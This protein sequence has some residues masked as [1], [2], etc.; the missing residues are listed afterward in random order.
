M[1]EA[2]LASE[3]EV[4][5]LQREMMD[6]T[7]SRDTLLREKESNGH[8]MTNSNDTYDTHGRLY[9]AKYHIRMCLDLSKLLELSSKNLARV[10]TELE[11]REKALK[12][13]LNQVIFSE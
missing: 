8:S 9:C 7:A 11:E 6:L 5:R 4:K 10:E 2:Q 13:Q 3:K 1:E 12:Q